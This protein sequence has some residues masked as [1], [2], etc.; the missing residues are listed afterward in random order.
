MV[1]DLADFSTSEALT[2]LN[3]KLFVALAGPSRS[4]E[5]PE[6]LERRGSICMGPR[7]SRGWFVNQCWDFL[8]DVS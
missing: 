8:P 4:G 2:T 1:N 6:N 3:I 7:R 5:N